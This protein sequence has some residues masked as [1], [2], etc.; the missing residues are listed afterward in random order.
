MKKTVIVSKHRIRGYFAMTNRAREPKWSLTR[1]R[2]FEECP[3]RYYYYYHFAP[4]A[5][6][7]PDD[8]LRLAAE[9][10]RI[11]TLDMWVGEVVHEAIQ[12]TL[13]HIGTG[14]APS[15]DEIKSYARQR[16]RD[17]WKA[18]KEQSWRKYQDDRHPNLFHHYYEIP[19]DKATTDRLKSK[20][21]TSLTNF[22]AS[23]VFRQIN[24]TPRD[25]WLP[26]E[27]YASFRLDGLLMYVKFDF[28]MK[29]GAQLIVYDWKTGRP[30]QDVI[31]QLVCYALYTADKWQTPI[32]N[33]RVCAVHLH[34]DVEL[35]EHPVRHEDIE[36]LRYY[37]KQSF[38]AMV[39]CLRD[40]ENNVAVVGGFPMTENLRQCLYCSFRGLCPQGKVAIGD[41]E[42]LA[43][44][45][46][47]EE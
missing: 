32:D 38:D 29:D 47:W 39:K 18:S 43:E 46:I 8:E 30:S 28:A 9:M 42:D 35:K 7:H 24:A 3:R 12:W 41:I 10:R 1:S 14:N 4:Q 40:P 22:V 34:P 16:L 21:Y 45:D 11:K 5:G 25:R 13:E 26:I 23:E 17:G 31:R 20:V 6:S 36:D 2:M 15:E 33:I 19:V 27:K 44:V 37:V